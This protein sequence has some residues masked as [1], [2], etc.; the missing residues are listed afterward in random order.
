MNKIPC[1]GT[2]E[3]VKCCCRPD[4][5]RSGDAGRANTSDS[6]D[7][8][9]GRSAATTSAVRAARVHDAGRRADDGSR[10]G[11]TVQPATHDHRPDQHTDGEQFNRDSIKPKSH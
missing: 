6:D 3:K 2:C 11:A 9:T 8:C 5:V 4:A 10:H 1:V 7:G